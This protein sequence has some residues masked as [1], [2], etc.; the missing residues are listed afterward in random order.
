MPNGQ[1]TININYSSTFILIMAYNPSL[2]SNYI[3]K[4]KKK[5]GGTNNDIR[6]Y[7]ILR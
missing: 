3:Y 2:Q 6:K 4:K 1:Y 7:T 5:I